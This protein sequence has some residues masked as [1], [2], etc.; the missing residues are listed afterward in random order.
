MDAKQDPKDKPAEK[1]RVVNYVMEQGP[2]MG[3]PVPCYIVDS[4]MLD[5]DEEPH[6]M[7]NQVDTPD[8]HYQSWVKYSKDKA[9]GS[10]HYA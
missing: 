9:P 6:V 1:R 8:V 2:D 10:W 5:G 3:K 7:L 4:K